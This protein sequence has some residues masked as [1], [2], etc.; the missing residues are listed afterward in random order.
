MRQ[1]YFE[2]K[3][4]AIKAKEERSKNGVRDLKV[5]KMPKGTRKSGKFAVC[6]E[7]EYLN[8]Y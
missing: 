4:A 2:T 3:Q 7:L 8:T 5:F 1:K 6:T